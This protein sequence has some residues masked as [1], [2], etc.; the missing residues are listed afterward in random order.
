METQQ[1]RYQQL[2]NYALLGNTGMYFGSPINGGSQYKTIALPSSPWSQQVDAI[3]Y[4][5]ASD[6]DQEEYGENAALS[7]MGAYEMTRI[8]K[9]YGVELSPF[10]IPNQ[11]STLVTEKPLQGKR[12]LDI[13]CGPGRFPIA[14]GA[15][16]AQVNAFDATASY[17]DITG[18]KI[19]TTENALRQKLDVNLSQCPAE[20]Y[21]YGLGQYDGISCMFGVLNHVELGL[22]LLPNIIAGLKPNGVFNLS[23]YGPNN[24][25]VFEQTQNGALKD[26]QPS[27][28]QK[29]AEGGILLGDSTEVLPASFPYPN[30]IMQAVSESGLKIIDTKGLLRIASLFPREPNNESIEFFFDLLDKVDPDAANKLHRYARDPV[31]LLL[32]SFQYDIKNQENLNDFAYL[33]VQST[34]Q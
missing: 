2:A 19:A 30:E 3:E 21:D 31:Q 29:R 17:L 28:L 22:A 9:S 7:R 4:P 5:F 11:I 14:L 16:G 34:K 18:R 10:N 8:L 13:G 27:I 26:Y 32:R 24:A 12:F 33:L 23:M 20:E 6:Y 1:N 15:L 25:L